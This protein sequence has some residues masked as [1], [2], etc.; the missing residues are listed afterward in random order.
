MTLTEEMESL[1]QS[2]EQVKE[3]MILGKLPKD[4]SA[5]A[6]AALS[7][8]DAPPRKIS[9]GSPEEYMHIGRLI[10]EK[11]FPESPP[12]ERGGFMKML[13]GAGRPPAWFVA[14]QVASQILDEARANGYEIEWVDPADRFK[15]ESSS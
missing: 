13:N 1:F 12:L 8:K 2:D 11:F 4:L 7:K 3:W 14:L 9:L 10:Q 15:N 5:I 6:A